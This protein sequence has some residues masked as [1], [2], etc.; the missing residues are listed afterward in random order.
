MSKDNKRF[1]NY[2]I[3]NRFLAYKKNK[4][5]TLST[6]NNHSDGKSFLMLRRHNSILSWIY[7]YFTGI[8]TSIRD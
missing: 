8:H 2:F 5:K 3:S 4:E 7:R 1:L 6:L